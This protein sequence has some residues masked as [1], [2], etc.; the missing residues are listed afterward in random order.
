MLTFPWPM[1]LLRTISGTME[2][3]AP[4]AVMHPHAAAVGVGARSAVTKKE[5]AP[6]T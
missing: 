4:L 1:A 6:T 2:V 3:L 5:G